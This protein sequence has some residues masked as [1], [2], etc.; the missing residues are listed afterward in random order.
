MT[1]ISEAHK[2]A[3]GM[4]GITVSPSFMAS[5]TALLELLLVAVTY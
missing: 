2:V 4:Q 3:R 5:N 1:H